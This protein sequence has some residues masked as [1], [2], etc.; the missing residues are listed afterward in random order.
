MQKAFEEVRRKKHAFRE[1][2]ALKRNKT[3]HSK[4]KDMAE[5]K[6]VFEEKGLDTSLVEERMRNRSRSKSLMDLK[7]KKVRGDM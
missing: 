6:E 3:A 7:A 5:L 2:H 1:E 4:N